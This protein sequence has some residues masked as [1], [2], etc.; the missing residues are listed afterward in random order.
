MGEV[1]VEAVGSR[2]DEFLDIIMFP[3]DFRYR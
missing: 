2:L 3:V 1:A